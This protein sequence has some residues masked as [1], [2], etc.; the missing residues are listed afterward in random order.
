[1]VLLE[2]HFDLAARYADRAVVL[3]AGRQ[4]ASGTPREVMDTA[5]RH[6]TACDALRAAQA[7]RAAGHWCPDIPAPVTPLEALQAFAAQK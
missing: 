5:L 3:Q 1:M 6:V 7:A 4:V 2:S